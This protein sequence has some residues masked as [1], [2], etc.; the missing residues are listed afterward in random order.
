MKF[1]CGIVFFALAGLLPVLAQTAEGAHPTGQVL[2]LNSY[3]FGYDWSDE[4]L[5]GFKEKIDKN[6]PTLDLFIENLDTKKFH[7]KKHFPQLA[8]LFQNKYQ[9]IHFDAVV[10]MDNA[11]LEFASRYRHRLFPDSPLL[12][13]GINN[14]QPELIANQTNITGVAERHDMG[15]TLQLALAL[16]PDIRSVVVLHDYTDTGLAMKRQ[17]LSVADEFPQIQFEFLREQTL[18]SSL[19]YLK[20]LTRDKIVLT[21]SY[22]VEKNGQ[23]YTQ[24][25]IARRLGQV[26]PVPIYA[27]H[28]EQLGHGVLGGMMLRGSDQGMHV[29]EQLIRVLAGESA[30]KIPVVTEGIARPGFDY[31]LL[32]K[33]GFKVTQIP[34]GMTSEIVNLPSLAYAV[35]KKTFWSVVGIIVVMAT[36]MLFLIINIYRRKQTERN[37][38]LSEERFRQ[39]IEQAPEAIVV[40]DNS[41]DEIVECNLKA[42]ELF[43]VSK[44]ELLRDGIMKY[45]EDEQ[46][47]GLPVEVSC[48]NYIESA[49]IGGKIQFQRAIRDQQGKYKL[50]EVLLV[51]LP[52]QGRKILR[53]SFIDITEQKNLENQIRQMEKMESIGQLA[54]GIA[55]DFNNQLASIIGYNDILSRRLGDEKLRRY[56][57]QIKTAANR[58]TDLIRKLL[59]FSR[60][61]Q[62]V[63][64]PVD[65]NGI[66]DEVIDVLDRS[67]DKKIQIIK[68]LN[69]GPVK[70]LG[71]PGQ[72]QNALLNLSLNARDAMPS[73]GEIRFET[74]LTTLGKDFQNRHNYKIVPGRYLKI[75][76]TDTGCGMDKETQR[77]IFEP[78]FTTKEQGKGTGMGLASVYGAILGHRGH[79]NVY[80]EPGQGS[81]FHLYLPVPE[82]AA[83]SEK[84]AVP[85]GPEVPA[86]GEGHVLVVDDEDMVR[87]MTCETLE[88]L[89]FK[90]SECQSGLSAEAIYRE[91][92]R[93]IDLVLVDMTMPKNDG[94]DTLLL[95]KKINPDVRAVLC[96]GY[97]QNGNLKSHLDFGFKSFIGK[98]FSADELMRTISSV[99][100]A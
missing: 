4:E 67:I 98:P 56:T 2:V 82:F 11:A 40:I 71:D 100:N 51:H 55:H 49:V 91:Q 76:T 41:R 46:P 92:W 17:L 74:S 80:S 22:T 53:Q 66:L 44:E 16:Q 8:D 99:M 78:F 83:E 30:T 57:D 36:L 89:G 37:L 3:N 73:G 90:V 32:K 77:H 95:L 29:A 6:T 14:Y 84:Q 93:E 24:S 50:C 62:N 97:S 15:G 28:H 58:S 68:H 43:G 23:T 47:D 9:S 79:I 34:V 86:R 81:S 94:R 75:S 5:R 25:D 96:S 70:V 87:Q 60:K 54:G 52:Y 18:V 26:S 20:T 72:L 39:L 35:S 13:C 19:Q 48:R 85:A 1:L 10:A 88:E 61:G 63:T 69:A 38:R 7:N 65:I 42:T 12:F 27:V 64:V 21:L 33:F 31:N 59:D 45:Y